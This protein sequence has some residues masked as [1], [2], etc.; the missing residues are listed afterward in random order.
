MAEEIEPVPAIRAHA[1]STSRDRWQSLSLVWIVATAICGCILLGLLAT[2]EQG[3]RYKIA[4]VS[5]AFAALAAALRSATR[6]GALAGAIACFC[7][8]WWTRDLESPLLLSAL[9]PL[10]ALV[11]LTSLATRAGRRRK[12]LRGLAERSGGRTASQVLANLG[13]AALIVTPIG[14]YA[15]AIAGLALP[16][17]PLLLSAASL[18]A[19]AEAAADTVSSELG[20]AFGRRTY[21][22]T[23]LRRVHRGTDGGISA[24]GSAAG[25]LAAVVVVLVGGWSMRLGWNAQAASLA[26][27]LVGFL[28]DSLLGAT[29]E[30]RGWIG[31]DLVNL[32]STAVA[33]FSLLLLA[34]LT[35]AFS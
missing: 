17:D 35:S 12:Q 31:N 28:A 18:A 21:L 6:G 13:V 23:T 3:G 20:Q 33:S 25:V 4:A 26:A 14:A 9:L 29:I 11:I 32:S 34:R 10:I 19:L 1:V 5:L 7:L 24:L 16:L 22:L 27:A 8:T 2:G 15:G 30:R